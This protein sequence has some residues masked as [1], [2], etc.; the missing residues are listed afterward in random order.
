MKKLFRKIK[1]TVRTS[2]D[3]S[4]RYQGDIIK[5]E[6]LKALYIPVPKVACSSVKKVIADILDVDVPMDGLAI[7]K[8]TLPIVI[9]N[10]L[11]EYGDY[12]KFGFVKNPWDRLVSCYSE[13]IKADNNFFGTTG[14]FVHGVHKGLL[15]YGVFKANMPFS[16]FLDAVANIPDEQA[17][18]HFRSQH[19][20]LTDKNEHL[21][22]DFLGRFENIEEDVN[23]VFE[24]LNRPDV[25][26][27]KANKTSHS[28][29]R[30]CYTDDMRKIFEKRYSDDID[31]FNYKF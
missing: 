17:D 2:K 20:F 4:N 19:T 23:H 5:I 25:K 6:P 11:Q 9:R 26:I 18:Q 8:A 15:K 24:K 21:I 31:L 22:L 1:S 12:W 29:Y 27:S 28:Q 30:E 13:K 10:E 7:H 14:S 16:E 3:L